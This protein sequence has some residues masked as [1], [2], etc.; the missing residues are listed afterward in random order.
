[1]RLTPWLCGVWTGLSLVTGS[2][3]AHRLFKEQRAAEDARSDN[4]TTNRPLPIGAL[5]MIVSFVEDVSV[6]VPGVVAVKAE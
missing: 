1:M 4:G 3:N 6:S 2:S 5:D